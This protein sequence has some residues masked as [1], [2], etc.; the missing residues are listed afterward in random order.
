MD[1]GLISIAEIE[2][3]KNQWVGTE[4]RDLRKQSRESQGKR[5]FPEDRR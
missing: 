3:M 2:A 4:R 1:L 5:K